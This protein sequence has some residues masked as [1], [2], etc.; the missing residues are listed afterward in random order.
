MKSKSLTWEKL[1]HTS[2]GFCQ[3]VP[4]NMFL[5]SNLLELASTVADYDSCKFGFLLEDC[6]STFE[7]KVAIAFLLSK[8]TFRFKL[9]FVTENQTCL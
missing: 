5:S 9:T 6:R 7:L 3:F 4:C 1:L 8:R 2:C